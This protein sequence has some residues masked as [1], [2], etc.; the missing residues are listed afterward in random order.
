[1]HVQS[2]PYSMLATS[3]TRSISIMDG[4]TLVQAIIF[5]SRSYLFLFKK[6]FDWKTGILVAF[7]TSQHHGTLLIA[8]RDRPE[9]AF[10]DASVN[11][12]IMVRA[13][14][15]DNRHTDSARCMLQR[16]ATCTQVSA[17]ADQ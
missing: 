7:H 8:N 16:A 5:C 13:I 6:V 11:M 12:D 2:I 3:A 15:S 17:G 9:A 1:M 4:S 10:F 14:S